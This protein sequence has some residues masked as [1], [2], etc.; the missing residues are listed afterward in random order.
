MSYEHKE[1]IVNIGECFQFSQSSLQDYVDC[2][3]RFLLRHL[4][5]L[6]WPS[7]EAE[8]PLQNERFLHLGQLF[9]Q[10]V[11]Q[12]QLGIPTHRLTVTIQEPE[13][14]RWWEN[15]LHS[16]PSSLNSLLDTAVDILTGNGA[17]RYPEITLCAPIVS[18]QLIAKYDLLLC[19]DKGKTII[20]D[21][22]T[23]RKPLP[24]KWLAERMQTRVYPYLL[25]QAGKFLNHGE[26]YHPDQIEMLYWLAEFP[27]QT[28]RFQY[29]Q[30]QYQA[31]HEYLTGLVD[32]IQ[33]L[34]ESEFFLTNQTSHCRFC[35][36]RSLCG[37]GS[38]AG[39][40]E[41]S[42][43]DQETGPSEV[44]FSWNEIDEIEM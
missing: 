20:L 32:E 37:R 35:T 11:Y 24:H 16:L 23:T 30:E 39:T 10:L 17:Q 41:E 7:L 44:G 1:G 2:P 8:P 14:Q 9:H 26:P 34:E 13:L 25:I 18:H 21:W 29:S 3:R 22:K 38:K 43:Q 12:H 36:Y 28:V 5:N 31:D 4:R 33:G 19:L 40:F 6:S 42:E 27:T 15:Y